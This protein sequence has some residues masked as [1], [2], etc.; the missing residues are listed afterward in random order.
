[1]RIRPLTVLD[2]EQI[3]EVEVSSFKYPY[4]KLI[5]LSWTI[6]HSDTSVVAIEDGRI[7]GYCI[8][9]LEKRGETLRGHILSI[10]VMPE[11]RG[12]GIG[13]RLLSSCETLLRKRGAR[14]VYL[15]VEE[16]NLVAK[17]LY[18]K[19]GYK[20]AGRIEKYYPWGASA[21]IMVKKL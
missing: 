11:Y 12:R 18:E 10:A 1:M 19:M 2:I 14:Y 15:E 17:R 7:V 21:L 8:S 9:A 4:S 13:K 3:Y 20:V 5:L 16:D 6:L